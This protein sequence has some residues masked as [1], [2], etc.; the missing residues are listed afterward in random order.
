MNKYVVDTSVA[1]KFFAEEEDSETSLK[2]LKLARDGNITLLAPTLIFYEIIN[3]FVSNGYPEKEILENS[4]AFHEIADLKII[5]IKNPSLEALNKAVEIANT[6]T[7]GQGYIS[8]YDATFHALALLEN[9]VLI[10]ADKKHYQ[11]TKNLVGS[12]ML[13]KDF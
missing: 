5:E 1:F 2:I 6:D 10:T 7:K 3:S 9:A 11:K 12:V 4:E 13:L 8:S